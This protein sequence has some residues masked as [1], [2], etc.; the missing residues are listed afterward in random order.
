MIYSTIPQGSDFVGS[1]PILTLVCNISLTFDLNYDLDPV[2]WWRLP[3]N[4]TVIGNSITLD[5]NMDGGKYTCFVRRTI[6]GKQI[7]KNTTTVIVN[8]LYKDEAK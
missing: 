1:R 4:K 8:G 7:V 5:R 3:N 6:D 2:F